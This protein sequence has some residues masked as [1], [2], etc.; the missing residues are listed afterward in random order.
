[1]DHQQ[2]SFSAAQQAM[3]TKTGVIIPVYFPDGIDVDTAGTFLT[4]TVASFCG[5]LDDPS[6]VCLSLDGEG[7]ALEMSESL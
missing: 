1:M 5:Q 2:Y 6:G 4:D 3:S 7:L